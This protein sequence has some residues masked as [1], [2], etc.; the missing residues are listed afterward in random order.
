[1]SLCLCLCVC[2]NVCVCVSVCVSVYI[3]I[4]LCLRVYGCLSLRLCVA[5]YICVSVCVYVSMA[6]YF[7]DYVSVYV[8][9][10]VSV[11][12]SKLGMCVY[13][14]DCLCLCLFVCVSICVCVCGCLYLHPSL[15]LCLCVCQYLCLCHCLR[16]CLHPCFCL[17]SQSPP[18]RL[19]QVLH[20]VRSGQWTEVPPVYVGTRNASIIACLY[21]AWRSFCLC[22]CSKNTSRKHYDSAS[23]PGL[24]GNCPI[25]NSRE[26][27]SEAQTTHECTLWRQKPVNPCVQLAVRAQDLF[28]DFHRGGRVDARVWCWKR[29]RNHDIYESSSSLLLIP[30][31]VEGS[32]KFVSGLQMLRSGCHSSAVMHRFEYIRLHIQ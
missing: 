15:C 26:V 2:V 9:V 22:K 8:C 23:P 31:G 6:V 13:V 10:Y 1:M 28:D 29:M 11:S 24:D 30:S 5:V 16:L 18:H 25:N 17:W 27:L 7:C 12:V 20:N 32:T 21:W 3:C 19:R 14:C 4:C